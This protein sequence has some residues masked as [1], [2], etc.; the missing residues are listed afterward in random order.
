[1]SIKP[2]NKSNKKRVYLDY[3]AGAPIDKDVLKEYVKVLG[4]FA[5]PTSFYREALDAKKIYENA[6]KRIS[7]ILRARPQEIVFTSGAT[8][9]NNMALLGVIEEAKKRGIK[10]PHIISSS[11]EHKSILEPLLALSK[12]GVSVTLLD[13]DEKGF[14]DPK[15]VREALR[16]NTVLVSI[17]YVN[18]EIGSI[19]PIRDMA[20][21]IRRYKKEQKSEKQSFVYPL[22]HTD[23]CQAANF[24]S[25]DV[26]TLGIDLMTLHS[27]KVY[28]P[29]GIGA[30][31]IKTGT[32]ISPIVFGGGQEE[33]LRSGRENTA[34]AHAF[35]FALESAQKIKDK[36]LKRVEKLR[37]IF[38]KEVSK[39]IPNAVINGDAQSHIPH[40]ASVTIPDLDAEFAVIALDSKGFAVSSAS[41]CM[42]TQKDSYS[43]VIERVTGS[44]EKALSTLRVSFGRDTT[45]ENIRNCVKAISEVQFHQKF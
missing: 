31:Y 20:K 45:A 30:L 36:E 15:K 34:L 12:W 27:P 3:A 26:L 11:I 37:E 23:A 18:N 24:L 40:I 8:E 7:E 4:N 5:N 1:M 10:N 38:I 13:P 2:K 29:A 9:S 17:M 43:Y 39:R 22:L 14:I 42:S 32:P 35:S 6:R 19:L 33:N 28:G 16:E 41:S 25:L 21:E 44:R